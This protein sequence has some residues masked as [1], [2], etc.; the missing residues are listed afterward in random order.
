MPSNKNAAA[1]TDLNAEDSANSG[2]GQEDSGNGGKGLYEL[3]GLE[4]L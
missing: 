2:S 3:D 4:N 1:N